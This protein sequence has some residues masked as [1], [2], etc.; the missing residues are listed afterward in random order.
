MSNAPTSD[1]DDIAVEEPLEIRIASDPLATLMRTPGEDHFLTAGFLYSEGI[2]ASLGDLGKIAHC[3]RPSDAGF[4]N[5]VDV[6]PGPGVALAP[7]LSSSSER[8]GIVSSACG[9]CGRQSIDDL[10]ART[11]P[12]PD[13]PLL[14]AA[15][16]RE[17]QQ[18]LV[19][20]QA[21][22]S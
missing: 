13:G 2:I 8:R 19:T 21:A 9:V 3:G 11:A 10:L 4:G 14:P 17:S 5:L 16:V 6:S 12:L 1:S 22:F 20:E 7:E 18:K 15:I